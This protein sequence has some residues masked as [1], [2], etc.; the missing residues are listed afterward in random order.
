MPVSIPISYRTYERQLREG[1]LE[2]GKIPC[3]RA[4]CRAASGG[5]PLVLSRSR[6]RRPLVL[7]EVDEYGEEQAV[8]VA[9]ILALAR[10]LRCKSRFRVLPADV[11]PRKPYGWAVIEALAWAYFT[12]RQSLRAVAWSLL[13]ER[14]PAHT[15]LHRWTEGLGAY[16]LGRAIGE[17]EGATPAARIRSESKAR[18]AER[19]V[20]EEEEI[21]VPPIRYRSPERRERLVSGRLFLGFAC[22]ISQTRPPHALSTWQRLL[23][24]WSALFVILFRSGLSCTSAEHGSS[25]A[26]ARCRPRGRESEEPP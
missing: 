24:S 8:T 16:A 10:C 21:D 18:F 1:A 26:G 6:V 13:G 22:C 17:V 14:T 23:L 12:F 7:L 11:L 4:G 25:I 5:E 15:T 3:L 20:P 9:A 19:L 2:I